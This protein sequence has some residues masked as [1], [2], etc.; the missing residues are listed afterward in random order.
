MAHQVLTD[1]Y[2]LVNSVNLSPHIKTVTMPRERRV[3]DN[4]A[5]GAAAETALPGLKGQHTI[6][7]EAYQDYASAQVDAT[8]SP[9]FDAATTFAVEIRPTSGARSTTNP[10]WTGTAFVSKYTPVA[11]TVGQMQMAPIELTL[12]TDLARQTS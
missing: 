7:L 5:M 8:I 2:V 11:G 4:T 9:L 6:V 12:T 3:V 10:A 1:A